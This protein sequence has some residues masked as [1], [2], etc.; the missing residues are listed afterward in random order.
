MASLST[1]SP[2]STTTA[3]IATSTTSL[4][5][6]LH[7]ISQIC[8]LPNRSNKYSL[9]RRFSC[10]ANNNDHDLNPTNPKIDRRNVLLGLGGL[11]G[12]AGLRADPFAFAAPIAPPD[13]SKCGAADFPSGVEPTNCCPP[14]P[15]QIVDFKLPPPSRV[16]V[17]P[18]AH[19]VD[20]AYIAK[21]NR[22]VQLMR[23]LPD[24]DPRSFKQQANIHCAYCDGAYEQVGFP[25]LDIQVHSS[26]L[27]LPFHRW[28]LYFFERI[29][30]KLINDPN[31]A[32]PFWNWD[33]PAGM[34]MP[35]IYTN[36]KSPLY[37]KFR[38]QNHLPPKLVDLDFNGQDESI[39]NQAQIQANLTIMYRQIVSNGR[40]ARLFMG[41]SYR[42][43]DDPSPGPGSLENIPHGPVHVWTGDNTQP[44][45]EDMGNFYSAGRDPIFFAHHSNIDRMWNIWKT[46]GGRRQDYTDT[47]F[48]DAAFLFYDENSQLVRVKV[49]DCLDTKKLGYVYQD[50][51][52][53]WLNSRPTPRRR[54]VDKIKTGLKRIGVARADE[55]PRASFP[56]TLDKPVKTL[57]SRPKKKRSKKEKDE[58]D[59]VL[60]IQ[61]IEF[62]RNVPIKFD[63]FIN[64]EDDAPTGPDKS[65][66]AGS[67]VSVPHKH[68]SKTKLS[69]CLRLD[70]TELLEDLDAED[71]ENVVV[72]L[73][74]KIG[75]GHVSIGGLKIEFVS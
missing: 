31:F 2:R 48:L 26:W 32:M 11:G 36:T 43:G 70:I 7:K 37:D 21:F 71:D 56:L 50:V 22:A 47:D 24:S 60:V 16:R 55:Y 46:L 9:P 33:A 17:R 68:K 38:N 13:L 59:E 69:T 42:A 8:F 54:V 19:A 65:E 28:Y 44:N 14:F 64:D 3:G 30:G 52:I 72:T 20:N 23:A 66:F 1:T 75:T 73:V 45:G 53:P 61:G 29:L 63:V 41:E 62:D 39:S 57:V 34:Q 27:F 4:S 10:K 6:S 74:P 5:P 25:D 67:F 35:A 51:D 15:A 49:R 18:P 12:L 40:S 58:E